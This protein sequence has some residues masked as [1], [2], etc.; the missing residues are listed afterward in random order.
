MDIPTV[1]DFDAQIAGYGQRVRDRRKA[2]GLSL[3]KVAE[4][5]GLTKS[6]VWE[7]ENGKNKNPTLRTT[8]GLCRALGWTFADLVGIEAGATSLHPEAMKIAIQVDAALKAH[9]TK[10]DAPNA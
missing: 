2:L 10:G 6:Y 1:D 3:D 7:I 9:Q 5:A 8:F 4:R